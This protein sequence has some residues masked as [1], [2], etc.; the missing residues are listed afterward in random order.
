MNRVHRPEVFRLDDPAI[1]VMPAVEARRPAGNAAAR[2]SVDVATAVSPAPSARSRRVPWAAIFW[3]SAAGL[4]LLATG[5]G[6]A[7]LITDLFAR[8]AWL[9]GIGT[10]LAAAAVIALAVMVT[11]EVLGLARLATIDATRRR[12][13]A[14]LVS[15]DRDAGRALGRDLIVLTK[16]LP[17]LA[18]P[19]ARL[20][21]HLSDIIDGAD[22][23]R[24]TEREL[25]PPLDDEARRLVT[26]AVKRVSV[27]TAVSPRAAIAMAFVLMTA[28][29][30]VR[31]LALLYG[32]RPGTLGLIK[33]MRQTVTH[34]AVTGG[35]AAGDGLIQQMVGHGVAAKLSTRLGEGVL[36]GLLTARLGLAAIESTR[37]LPFAALPQPA[38]SE[39]AGSILRGNDN[40]GI[41]ET[42]Q[43]QRS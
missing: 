1:V 19:R 36:N 25:M 3:T 4:L 13:A 37:P 38:L 31:R 24:L 42:L 20:E 9:G 26:G 8:A 17:Q 32:G 43:D 10:A 27:V 34:L 23:V 35:M 15:D 16:R 12:A 29:N 28:L 6:V 41:D 30:L 7:N 14:I 5:L 2:P 11:R 21:S 33:L 18:R 40:R 39:L 22:L